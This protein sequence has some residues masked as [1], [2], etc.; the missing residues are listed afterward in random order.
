MKLSVNQ[1]EIKVAGLP[2]PILS[3]SNLV[4]P[5]RQQVAVLGPSGSGKSTLLQ[6]LSGLIDIMPGQLRW[7]DTDPAELSA[8]QRDRWRFEHIGLVMQDFYLTP[9][10]SAMENLLLPYAFR[11]GHIG[12]EIKSR[13]L[14]LLEAMNFQRADS[15]IEGLS[16]GEMQRV[17]I[18]RALLLRPKVIIA[19]EPT[20]SLDEENARLIGSLLIGLAQREQCSLIVS[21]HDKALAALMQRRIYLENGRIRHE[22]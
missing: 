18:A 13:A 17:A 8:P 1:L 21:T 4:I 14:S 20:A 5:S 2:Q 11:Y 15:K 3:L 10:L 19:D 9:G 16:R 12:A 7:Q 22:D 6:A